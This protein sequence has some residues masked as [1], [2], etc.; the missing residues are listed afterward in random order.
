M[1]ELPGQ[2]VRRISHSLDARIPLGQ[3]KM[4]DERAEFVGSHRIARCEE[5]RARA[6][7]LDVSLDAGLDQV[8]RFV[9][10]GAELEHVPRTAR[11]HD[12]RRAKQR[13]RERNRQ[14]GVGH[15]RAQHSSGGRSTIHD[16]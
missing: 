9:G 5:C 6:E 3:T 2:H 11:A 15:P 4:G 12:V 1:P 7:Q 8:P 16:S 13:E 14:G 10:R